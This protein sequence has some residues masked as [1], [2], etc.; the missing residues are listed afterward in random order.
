MSAWRFVPM[1]FLLAAVQVGLWSSLSWAFRLER[2]GRIAAGAG[3]FA[4]A[5]FF[6]GFLALGRDGLEL[7]LPLR[8]LVEPLLALE[9]LSVPL[10]LVLGMTVSVARRLEESPSRRIFLRRAAT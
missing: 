6:I 5:A 3:L 4:L 9:A 8:L 2:R 1:L 7:G 10:M